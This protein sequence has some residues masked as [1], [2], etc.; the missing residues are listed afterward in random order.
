VIDIVEQLEELATLFRR[1]LLSKAEFER[2]KDK[3]LAS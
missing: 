3:V 1:S 2:Q